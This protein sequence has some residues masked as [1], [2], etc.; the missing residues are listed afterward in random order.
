MKIRW[1][2]LLIFVVIGL[3][4][5]TVLYQFSQ[6]IMLD[7]V[8]ETE[9]KEAISNA[10]RFIT[11]LNLE[12]QGF[13]STVKDWASWDDTYQFIENNNTAY[14]DSNL[15]DQ[16]FIHLGLNFMLF[17]N[18]SRQ[19][20]FGKAFDLENQTVINLQ[21]AQISQI[22]NNNFLYT[23]DISQ[24]EGGLILFEGTP[25]LVISQPILTSAG[26]GPVRGALI[27]GRFLEKSET[28]SLE[29]AVGLPFEIF[30]IGSSQMPADF[31][32]ASKS[33]SFKEPVFAHVTN[34]TNIAGYVLLQDVSGTPIVITRVDTY[35]S[36]YLQAKNSLNYLI[37]SFA[38]L[39]IAI[40]AA[41][42]FS[43]DKIV[44]SR[45]SRLTNDVTKI[46]PKSEQRDYVYVKGT[47]ELSNLGCKIN[48]MITTIQDSRDELK[49]YAESLER[50]VEERT[51]EL[52][53]ESREAQKHI[54]CF[55]RYH[56][57][58]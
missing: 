53:K 4:L 9:S 41:T 30:A 7:G 17:I 33:L 56:F 45:V 51:L 39:G 23:N 28:D 37:V 55:S 46:D 47:D 36:A 42:A 44:L 2:T 21:D 31:Q 1:K 22:A 40:F 18:Q 3:I 49:K 48:G 16:T 13:N 20:V 29:E 19:L 58:S 24:S 10:Q 12:L 27:M 14:I 5:M 50:K 38:V 11:N 54:R 8:A 32:I 15:P 52:K 35:R 57:S 25:T 34:E 26:E 6:K 43:M